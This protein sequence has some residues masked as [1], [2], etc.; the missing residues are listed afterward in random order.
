MALELDRLLDVGGQALQDGVE[1]TARL[2]RR[3]HVDEEVV[4]GL[5]MLAHGVRERGAAFHVHARLL[6]DL[7]EGLV[8]LLAA[9]DLEALD[10]RETGVDH[11]REL[12]H[13][14]G[15]VLGGHAA[16]ELGKDHLLP[17]LLHGRDQDLVPPQERH[18]GFLV[19]R[20]ALARHRLAVAGLAF[21]DVSRHQ[22]L[23]VGPSIDP[24]DAR[25]AGLPTEAW[26]GRRRG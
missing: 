20:R 18:H 24:P 6:E 5:G 3:D 14:D 19:L 15:Q 10:E 2:A 23:L 25:G 4:E 12:A 9:Q 7:G 26:R 13:E 1:D 21:P 8:L 22:D 17:L 16:S 11:D